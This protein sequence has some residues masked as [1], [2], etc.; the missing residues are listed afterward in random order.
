MLRWWNARAPLVCWL[1]VSLLWG[2]ESLEEK[3]GRKAFEAAIEHAVEKETGKQATVETSPQGIVIQT[4][5]GNSMRLD[6]GSGGVPAD[7]PS[8]VPVY[9]GGKI[10]M[11]MK[12]GNGLTLTLET[13]DAPAQ[14]AEFY[15][16][17]L[18]HLKQEAAVDMGTSQTL[19][20]ADQSKPLQITLSVGRSARQTQTTVT[21]IVS[22]GPSKASSARPKP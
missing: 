22:R 19:I 3:L 10:G 17:K 15:R 20:W 5:D 6:T 2:C 1:A 7:W 13:A 8:D 16:S 14:V 18:A 11:S 21:L 12:V 9:P 4:Q